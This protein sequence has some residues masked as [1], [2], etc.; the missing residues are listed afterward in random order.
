MA[1]QIIKLPEPSE[2][3][4]KRIEEIKFYIF[5][6]RI[7]TENRAYDERINNFLES[8][9]DIMNLSK[10]IIVA[11]ALEIMAGPN[12][13]TKFE[14]TIAL[15]HSKVPIRKIYKY[16]KVHHITYYKIVGEY[17]NYQSPLIPVFDD[18]RVAQITK[19]NELAG[20]M[21]EIT[22]VLCQKN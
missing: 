14:T 13:P 12:R 10:S 3:D 15:A 16:T 1:R 18:T 22:E 7:V 20:K 9:C 17:I 6:M 11:S 19:F 8:L 4:L 5:I 2:Q 21:F